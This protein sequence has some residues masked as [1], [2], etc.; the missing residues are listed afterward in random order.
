MNLQRS[1]L[2]SVTVLSSLFL[3]TGLASAQE[4]GTLTGTVTDASS[5]MSL[6]G[7]QVVVDGTTIGGLTNNAGRYL[8]QNVPA[9]PQQVRAVLLGYGPM[10]QAVTVAAGETAVLDFQLSLSAIALD[11]VVVTA[12][13]EQR[14]REIGHAIGSIEAEELVETAPI[15][16][17]SDLIQGR[18]PGVQVSSSTGTVGM[19]SR[20]R[21]RGSSSI[22]LNN[23]P[24]LYVDGVRVES[25]S[26]LGGNFTAVG[27]QEPSRFD[28]FNPEDI[29][30]IEIIKGP[31]AATL[32][33]TEAANGVIRITTKAGRAGQTRWNAW[34]ETGLVQEKNRY[35][36]NYA[37]LDADGGSLS[38]LCLLQFELDGNCLQDGITSYQVLDDPNL[39][40]IDDGFR[41]QYGLSVTG[42]SETV[43]FYASVE[44]EGED[45]PY[46][47]PDADRETLLS[48]GIEITN[49]MERPMQ[50]DRLNLRANLNAQLAENTTIALRTGYLTSNLSYMGNDNNSFGFLPSAYFG[51]AFPGRDDAWGFQSPSELFGRDLFQD[52]ERFT[53]SLTTTVQPMTWL[54]ARGTF[55]LDFTSRQDISFFP[56]DIGVPGDRD[57]GWKDRHYRS[58][59]QYTVDLG[60]SAT[61]DLNNNVGS[62]TS[63]GAQYFRD[64][65]SG[66]DSWG[67]DIVNGAKSIN[68]AAQS[69]S[70]EAT[71]ENKT[72]GVFVEQQFSINDRLFLTGAIR[73]D[74]NSAFGRDFDLVYY[75]KAAISWLASEEDFFPEIGFLD[76]L[77]LRAAWGKSGLQPGSDDAL[78]T[79]NG[80]AVVDPTDATVSGAQIGEVGNALLEP[81]K[82]QEIELGFDADMFGGRLGLELT[83][84]DKETEA[85][86]VQAPLPPSQ[87][88]VDDRWV[89]VGLVTNKGW[90][91]SL[92]ALVLNLDNYQWDLTVSGSTNENLLV[93]LGDQEPIG[94]QTRFVEDYPLGGKWDLP[95]ESWNDANGNGIIEPDEIVVGSEL[96]FAGNGLP[97]DMLAISSSLTLF[98]RI[99][100]YG[101]LDYRGDYVSYN[102]TER[103]RCRFLLCRA[104]I[105]RT[106][107]L[108][109]QARAVA[110]LYHPSQ[111]VWGY[112]EDGSFWKLREVSATLMIPDEWAQRFRATRMNFT[113]TGRNLKTWTDYTGVD[114]EVN[115][116]G[117]GDNF[118]TDDFL[119]QPALRYW[120]FRLNLTF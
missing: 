58:I 46:T 85:A 91:A 56:R 103:F 90:E 78:R 45:G 117:S 27:G 118:G 116:N 67:F 31:A 120:T 43:N 19:G 26:S 59:F 62:R 104:L 61:F 3:F 100:L 65:F 115:W 33:G 13:G 55:G 22:S 75:P 51:G 112:F 24:L 8:I 107:E 23:S 32:Y 79:L 110:S 114:P 57:L 6:V 101:L 25:S 5:G 4:R 35:P 36:L 64:V 37:G 66:T 14:K 119:T 69:F 15:N 2:A 83:Y 47:L 1:L 11:E 76:Q 106:T 63:V 53:G 70:D 82:S 50:L 17:I 96:T 74:D 7:V 29:E 12:T 86:L 20:I 109:D 52:V 48:R 16:N 49:T 94:T 80:A 84:Y 60:A 40:P 89:N 28:D 54:A 18:A 111:S 10:T 95:L 34:V 99:R 87:G 108:D 71:A 39:S 41:Q 72:L 105:D 113:V 68:Q 38:E 98:D 42:G 77:R 44:Y 30:S 92:S 93:D 102:N 81:E 88:S 21:I 73:A 97:E 9:G